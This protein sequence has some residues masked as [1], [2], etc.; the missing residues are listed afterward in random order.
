[1]DDATV[2]TV[3]DGDGDI[4]IKVNATVSGSS[5]ETNYNC[6]YKVDVVSNTTPVFTAG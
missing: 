1:M 5:G 2:T 6:Y 3:V 4:H